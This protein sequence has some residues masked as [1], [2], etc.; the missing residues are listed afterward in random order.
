MKDTYLRRF[1]PPPFVLWKWLLGGIFFLLFLNVIESITQVETI[2]L[3]IVLG[4]LIIARM[5]AFPGL[6]GA[7]K[8]FGGIGLSISIG[9]IASAM[10]WSS[11]FIPIQW[12]VCSPT[13][14]RTNTFGNIFFPTAIVLVYAVVQ[15][16]QMIYKFFDFN[17][18]IRKT[19][20]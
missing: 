14:L 18:R 13:N 2:Q 10:L 6:S 7:R 16:I 20:N 11:C 15:I 1:Q 12:V 3:G 8:I 17:F 5:V 9:V 19:K 4:F